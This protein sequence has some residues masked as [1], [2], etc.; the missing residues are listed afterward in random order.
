M[1][2]ERTDQKISK[3]YLLCNTLE[4]HRTEKAY[5]VRVITVIFVHSKYFRGFP[6]GSN[7]NRVCL[8]YR[9]P[10]FNVWVRKILGEGTDNPSENPVDGGAWWATVRGVA[11]SKCTHGV[12]L[13]QF[14]VYVQ[15]TQQTMGGN[16]FIIEKPILQNRIFFL[17]NHYFV[18]YDTDLEMCWN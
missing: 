5:K 16:L 9:R 2:E 18:N 3:M 12:N 1:L 13:D 11:K 15:Y 4:H 6:G 8:R 10:E 14:L 17:F 7:G